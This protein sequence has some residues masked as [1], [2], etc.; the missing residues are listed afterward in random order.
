MSA[1]EAR[2]L[3]KQQIAVPSENHPWERGPMG[4]T[5]ISSPPDLENGCTKTPEPPAI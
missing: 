4:P 2:K 3:T 1:K 5:Q